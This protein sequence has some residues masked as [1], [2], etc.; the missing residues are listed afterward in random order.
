[1][2][3]VLVRPSRY[4]YGCIEQTGCFTVNVPTGEMANVCATCGS[5]SGRDVDKFAQ[6]QL[7]P[8][9]ASTVSA[10]AVAQCPL[11]YECEGVHSNDVLP[12][13]LAGQIISG[14]YPQGDYPRVYF[15]KILASWAA[16]NA[17]EL[18]A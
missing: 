4:T 8:E 2:W 6:T 16:A 1:M 15:G 12:Q 11:V 3:N 14:A 18:L 7:T 13:K 17:A 10:P 9:R 5:V